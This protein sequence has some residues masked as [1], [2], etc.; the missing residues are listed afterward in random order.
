MQNQPIKTISEEELIL[1][2]RSQD[3]SAVSVLYDMYSPT[4]FGVVLQIVK[5]DET[6]EDVLQEAFVKIWSSFQSYDSSKGRLFTWMIN[7]CR[8]LAIDKIRSKQYRVSQKTREIPTA[9]RAVYGTSSFKPEHIGLREITE[10]LSPEQ[11]QIIDLM[12]FEGLTQSEISEEFDIPL[13]TVKT[14]ARSAIKTLG[15]LFKGRD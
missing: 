8:N 2:L 11:K 12:Y 3:A 5:E 6:A 15:K 10:R 14:R 7:V 13:G 1:R 9:P 4:L